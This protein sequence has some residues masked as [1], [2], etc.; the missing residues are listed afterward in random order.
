MDLQIQKARFLSAQSLIDNMEKDYRERVAHGL[1]CVD[2]VS[3]FFFSHAL[4]IFQRIYFT[5]APLL[6]CSHWFSYC[7][8]WNLRSAALKG[9]AVFAEKKETDDNKTSTHKKCLSFIILIK[10]HFNFW[11]CN[12]NTTPGNT[13]SLQL[14]LTQ[15]HVHGWAH[16]TSMG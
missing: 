10:P 6:A 9:S 5:S 11:K 13:W 12:S 7:C 16:L 15:Q 14:N 2:M 4:N 8:R 3:C 1:V